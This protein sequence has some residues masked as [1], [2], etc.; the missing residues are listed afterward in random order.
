MLIVLMLICLPVRCL[1]YPPVISAVN[2]DLFTIMDQS[3]RALQ[4]PPEEFS[5][6]LQEMESVGGSSTGGGSSGNNSLGNSSSS[7]LPATLAAM[8]VPP[9]SSSGSIE[10]VT[11]DERIVSILPEPSSWPSSSSA[12]DRR[13]RYQRLR[14][15]ALLVEHHSDRREAPGEGWNLFI[16][17]MEG[18]SLI[19]NLVGL[20]CMLT[21]V[22]PVLHVHVSA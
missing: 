10:P 12:I 7:P 11:P 9:S 1:L 2:E 4:I 15:R 19:V 22:L 5:S 14:A 16:L 18:V 17:G 3:G 13:E 20:T 6:F 8:V 21:R